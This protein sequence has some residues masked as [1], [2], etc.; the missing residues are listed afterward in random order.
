M[1]IIAKSTLREFYEIHNDCETA[2][3]EWY[4]TVIKENWNTANDLKLKFKNASI[5]NNTR[6]VF[7]IKGNSYR[8]LVDVNYIFK[9]VFI[10]WFGTHSEYDKINVKTIKYE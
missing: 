1:R 4:N 5:I 9:L 7:N 8:L 10:V 2:I 6:V 3:N